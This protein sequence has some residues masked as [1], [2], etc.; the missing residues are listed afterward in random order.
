[1]KEK[2]KSEAD[3]ARS[4]VSELQRQGYTTYEEVS[5]GYGGKRADIV[6]VRGPVVAIVECKTKLSLK[7]LDQL[8]DWRGCAHLIIGAHSYSRIGH[9]VM[10]YCQL[11]GFGMWRVGHTEIDEY[12]CPRL[13]RVAD[14]KRLR[15][16]LRDEQRT[17][18]YAQA[19]TGGGYWTP[20]R[21]TV[22]D[23]SK[24]V[25]EQPGIE[26]RAAMKAI[27]HHYATERSAM[28]AIPALIQ[29]GVIE[30]LRCEGRPLRI[31]PA[32]IGDGITAR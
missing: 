27:K 21:Q 20:F 1:V 24:L 7:L 19:G 16:K 8:A 4:V 13:H 10:R 14:V 9:A 23:L 28:N 22:T 15:K 17:G 5:Y 12:V 30:G 25:K 3:M 11:E 6:G 2:N 26:L 29:K 18:E 31:F 32:A